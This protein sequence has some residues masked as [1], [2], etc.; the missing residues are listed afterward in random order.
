MP[1]ACSN[2][3]QCSRTCTSAT[4]HRTASQLIGLA[5]VAFV[6]CS[7][8]IPNHGHY[9]W[10]HNARAV[11]LVRVD[12]YA[13]TLKSVLEAKDISTLSTL[14]GEPHGH[15]VAIQ[16]ARAADLEL[17]FNLCTDQSW[18]ACQSA[19]LICVIPPNL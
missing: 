15:A 5:I 17:D 1:R 14:L 8:A 2:Q 18:N 3:R 12:E 9:I 16:C 7:V 10:E 19:T 4:T 11:V 13:E 6:I